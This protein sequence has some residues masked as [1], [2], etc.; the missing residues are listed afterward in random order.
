MAVNSKRYP[1]KSVE[2]KVMEY[3]I[4]RAGGSTNV[5]GGRV[6]CIA[7]DILNI[8]ADEKVWSTSITMIFTFSVGANYEPCTH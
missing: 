8:P 2:R 3:G 4:S 1:L 6:S 7:N 5:Q